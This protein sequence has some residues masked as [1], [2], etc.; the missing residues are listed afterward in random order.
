MALKMFEVTGKEMIS[1]TVQFE[2]T[3]QVVRLASNSLY[4]ARAEWAPQASG[5]LET[6]NK[7]EFH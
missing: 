7:S 5:V 1:E 6:K 2:Q 3:G 4:V